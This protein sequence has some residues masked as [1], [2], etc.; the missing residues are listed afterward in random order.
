MEP[1]I[2]DLLCAWEDGVDTYDRATKTNFKMRVWY[3][4]SLH[5]HPAYGL[6]CGWCVHGKYPCPVCKAALKFIWLAKGAKYSCFDLHRQFLPMDHPFRR[7]TKNFTKGVVVEDPPPQML[8]GPEVRAQ[9]NALKEKKEGGFVG[10][11]VEHAWTQK[12]GLWRLPYMDD[13]LL[14]HNI[15]MMHTEKNVAEALWGTIMDIPDKTKDN[16]KARVDQARLC[17]RPKYNISPPKEG[18]KWKKPPA[19]YVLKRD[20]RKEVLKWFQTLMFPDGYAANLRRGVN[21]ATMRINGL[22]SHDYHIW[23]ERLLPVMV[24]GY[25]PNHVW[26]VLAEL[27]N[28][29]RILCAKELSRTLVAKMEVEAPVL[30]CKL[31]KIFPPGFFNP[32]QHM[33]LHL[34]YEA[35][36]GGPVHGRWCYAIERLQK[37]LRTKC[38][39]KCKIEASIAEAYCTEEVTNFT[40]KYYA[41]TLPS[42]H[43]PTPRYNADE[44]ESNLSLFRG[45]LGSASVST[46]KNLQHQEWRTIMIYVLTNLSEVQPYIE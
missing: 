36:M 22:K 27:S 10:Y 41:D 33:I 5:D 18:K 29:F 42:V 24:R 7:D 30:L 44:N 35:R 28:F 34:P 46:C 26:L 45:Q 25:L 6:F 16:V 17:D 13:L 4:Y 31:E 8:T 32:M 11:G 2:D 14:P 1:L 9:L 20:Q 3:M 40:T 12:S 19:P 15:D 37:V 23:I 43:N 21:L 39:N 38:K